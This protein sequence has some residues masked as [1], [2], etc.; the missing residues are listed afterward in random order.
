MNLDDEAPGLESALDEL[1][2]LYGNAKVA[3][4]EDEV[5]ELENRLDDAHRTIEKLRWSNTQLREM[6]TRSLRNQ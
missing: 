5:K 6:L 4:L 2:K 1:M 3:S